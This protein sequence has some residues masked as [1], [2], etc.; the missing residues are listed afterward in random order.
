M[1][2]SDH[3]TLIL[4]KGEMSFVKKNL[5]ALCGQ[6]DRYMENN[7]EDHSSINK[8]LMDQPKHFLFSRTFYW[9]TGFL[10]LGLLSIGASTVHNK[11]DINTLKVKGEQH[12]NQLP[13]SEVTTDT[14]E[15]SKPG[16]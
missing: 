15:N 13:G 5:A 1:G 3:D 16:P 4:L 8:I 6:I 2:P 7:K 10:I 9:V 14:T 12:G 11:V